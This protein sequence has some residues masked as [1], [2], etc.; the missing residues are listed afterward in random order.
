MLTLGINWE[1][2]MIWPVTPEPPQVED[3]VSEGEIFYSDLE[4]HPGT[5]ALTEL[6]MAQEKLED[7]DSLFLPVVTKRWKFAE[8]T[9]SGSQARV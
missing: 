4:D 7:Y 1:G 8:Q 6:L 3:I 9:P 2:G 5:P